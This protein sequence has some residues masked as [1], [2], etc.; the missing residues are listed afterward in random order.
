M[1]YYHTVGIFS[2]LRNCLKKYLTTVMADDINY[3]IDGN[4]PFSC[5]AT[6]NAAHSV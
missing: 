5:Q 2:F 6:V 1:P 4:L 3:V